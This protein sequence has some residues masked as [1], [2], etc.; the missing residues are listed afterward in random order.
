MLV[1][2]HFHRPRSKKFAWCAN[3]LLQPG[4]TTKLELK[5][6]AFF[7]TSP[8]CSKSKWAFLLVFVFLENLSPTSI[9]GT[10]FLI[11]SQE[12]NINLPGALRWPWVENWLRL[13]CILSAC[14]DNKDL[15]AGFFNSLGKTASPISNPFCLDDLIDWLN[16]GD[17]GKFSCSISL[18]PAFLT[19]GNTIYYL[20]KR[21][22]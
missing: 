9:V 8:I 1:C 13:G 3:F 19:F 12:E 7:L 20:Y 6:A 10:S 16:Q 15:V 11:A 14:F 2:V 18:H 4:K 22:S 5:R 21:G 17:I